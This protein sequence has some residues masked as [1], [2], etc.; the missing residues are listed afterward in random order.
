MSKGEVIVVGL[1]PGSADTVTPQ[2]GAALRRATDVVGY[3]PY[4][5]R[6]PAVEGQTRHGSDNRVELERARH[7]LE[8]AQSGKTVAV[9]SSGDAGVFAMASTVFEALEGARGKDYGDVDVSVVPGIS[10]MLAAAA[11]TGAP[12]GHDF[13]VISLSDNLKPWTRIVQ[14]L[15]AAA[16]ADFVIAL[17]NPT[18]KERPTQLN[19]AF[20]II[21]K[22]RDPITPVIFATAVTRPDEKTETVPLKDANSVEA[23]MRTIVIIGS[24]ATRM[25][26]RDGRSA[27]V[28]TPRYDME[29][30]R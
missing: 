1:G 27:Y 20:D 19:K 26:E 30:V 17:Y 10:A 2:A 16:S 22:H 3:G 7:A 8:L 21:R 9:V 28:Y 25:I 14:R 15:E 6:V 12:L 18:S 24:S 23:D 29:S 5:A 11:R 13:C 4:L